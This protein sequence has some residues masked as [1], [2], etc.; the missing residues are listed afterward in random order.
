MAVL[1]IPLCQKFSFVLHNTPEMGI[2]IV[3]ILNI[4]FVVGGRDKDRIQIE[5][6]HAQI[7]QIIQLIHHPL[8]IAAVKTPHVHGIRKLLPVFHPDALIPDVKIFSGQHIVASIPIAEAVHINLVD[9]RPSGP[10]RRMEARHNAKGIIF[11]QFLS[12]S[13]LI[14]ITGEFSRLYLKIIMN[15]FLSYLKPVNIIIKSIP[16]LRKLH[17]LPERTADKIH[18]TYIIFQCP[19]TD[20]HQISRIR[21][22]RR[23]ELF[24]LITEQR[25]LI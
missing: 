23:P 4:I 14:V 16:A 12:H 15:R 18:R 8:E 13:Q 10:G 22:K 1:L 3:I 19:E 5:N 25:P 9:H 2:H 20:R 21:L 24:C 17:L 6:L 7:L 11:L